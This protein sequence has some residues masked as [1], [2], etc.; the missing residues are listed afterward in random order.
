MRMVCTAPSSVFSLTL[1][2]CATLDQTV[3]Q[4]TQ[5]AQD[6][7]EG[8]QKAK[9]PQRGIQAAN[10]HKGAVVLE[11]QSSVPKLSAHTPCSAASLGFH[12][13][14][15]RLSF[16]ARARELAILVNIWIRSLL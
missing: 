8:S 13:R 3:R 10:V 16:Q 6:S 5:R 2:D 12:C 4:H 1:Q 7:V 9:D 14:R 11:L 15:D